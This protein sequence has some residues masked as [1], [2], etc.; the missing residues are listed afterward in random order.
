MDMI[1]V[2]ETQHT[3]LKTPLL[4]LAKTGIVFK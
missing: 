2:S 3:N 4:K 1:N